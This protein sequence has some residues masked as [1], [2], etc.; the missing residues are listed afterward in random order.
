M[1]K[2][3]VYKQIANQVY[4]YHSTVTPQESDEM[5]H[6]YAL[7]SIMK[8]HMPSGSGID[9]GTKLLLEESTGEKLVFEVAYHHMNSTGFYCGWTTRNITVTYSMR[10]GLKLDF[11]TISVDADFTEVD[12][13]GQEYDNAE[14]T[15][16]NTD[17]YLADTYQYALENVIELTLKDYEPTQLSWHGEL[18]RK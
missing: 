18:V 1:Y 11:E 14:W 3:P 13:E 8:N 10:T 7:E 2:E 9:A 5:R 6:K 15:L 17:E 4:Q 16:E 12:D